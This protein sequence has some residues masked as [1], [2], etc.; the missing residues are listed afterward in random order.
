MDDLNFKIGNIVALKNMKKAK[1]YFNKKK[2]IDKN[3]L[4]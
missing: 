3:F 4:K 1:G 2:S